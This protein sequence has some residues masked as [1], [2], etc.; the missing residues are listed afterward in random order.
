MPRKKP[1][2]AA[3]PSDNEYERTNLTL[4]KRIKTPAIAFVEGLGYSLS[5][6]FEKL[7]E[8]QMVEAG[9]LEPEI[10]PVP[11]LLKKRK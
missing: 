1:A 5:E 10:K 2:P 11:E 3:P 4:R 7:L 9:V 6:Y 8:V